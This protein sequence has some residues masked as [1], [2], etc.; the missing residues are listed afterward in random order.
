[1]KYYFLGA[2]DGLELHRKYNSLLGGDVAALLHQR[3]DGEP[4]GVAERELVD[5]HLG[6]VI[7][8]VGVVP[9]IGAEPE[10]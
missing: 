3:A 7:A 4:H 2:P 6:L 5:Q 1:M 10:R 9:L 8:G